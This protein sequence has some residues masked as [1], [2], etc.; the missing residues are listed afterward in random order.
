MKHLSQC[1][2]ASPSLVDPP[3]SFSVNLARP[4]WSLSHVSTFFA[5]EVMSPTMLYDDSAS[6]QLSPPSIVSP[7]PD[8]RDCGRPFETGPF[9]TCIHHHYRDLA[10]SNRRCGVLRSDVFS[11]CPLCFSS[12]KAREVKR[13][14]RC[15]LVHGFGPARFLVCHL[16]YPIPG[17]V[18]LQVSQP[19][20]HGSIH[21]WAFVIG[22][23]ISLPAFYLPNFSHFSPLVASPVFPS[24]VP[25]RHLL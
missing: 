9:C 21:P 24:T 19:D 3:S 25:T 18:D 8:R 4:A 7:P 15:L 20:C 2:C 10:P 14:S 22:A 11:K 6:G 5:M 17:L 23:S 16:P 1:H 12:Q 13:T